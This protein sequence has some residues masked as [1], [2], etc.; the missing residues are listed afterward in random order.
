VGGYA[1][2]GLAIDSPMVGDRGLDGRR[3]ARVAARCRWHSVACGCGRSWSDDPEDRGCSPR[4]VRRSAHA[5][6]LL[7]TVCPERTRGERTVT[8]ASWDLG[9]WSVS[10]RVS[11]QGTPMV[12]LHSGPGSAADWWGVLER[13][14]AGH[15]LVAVNGFGQGPTSDWPIGDVEVDQY[16]Q[17]VSGLVGE[18]GEPVHLV[19]H[20]YGGAVALRMVS[21]SPRLVRSLARWRRA[22]S[23]MRGAGSSTT[24]TVWAAGVHCPNPSS[25]GCCG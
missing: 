7:H 23:R 18:L 16:V 1:V 14:A 20:S 13:F 11:G 21:S 12:F 6:A 9:R 17:M 8:L 24:T 19:G 3:R 15:R 4:G 2:V 5:D 10:C 22:A 25:R